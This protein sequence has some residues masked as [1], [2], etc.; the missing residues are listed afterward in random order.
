MGTHSIHSLL[1]YYKM[2]CRKHYI[3]IFICLVLIHKS[4][5]NIE[6]EDYEDGESS[7]E[8]QKIC[9]SP[10]EYFQIKNNTQDHV[11]IVGNSTDIQNRTLHENYF[12]NT[13]NVRELEV[14][15]I[16][17][18]VDKH[19]FYNLT[20]L[21]ILIF[22]MTRIS[23][24]PQEVF[25]GLPLTD[26]F[27]R[28]SNI[29][30][31]KSGTFDNLPT[32]ESLTIIS[33]KLKHLTYDTVPHNNITSL[34]YAYNEIEVIE[35]T[36]FANINKLEYLFLT[37]NKI[38]VFDFEEYLKDNLQL[39]ILDMGSNFLTTVN[40]MNL[41]NL[42]ELDLNANKIATILPGA[43]NNCQK[44]EKLIVSYNELKTFDAT[45]LPFHGLSKLKL[46]D[47][48]DNQMTCIPRNTLDLF[49]NLLLVF[50]SDNPFS[51]DCFHEIIIWMNKMKISV[52]SNTK[53]N[54]PCDYY[55]FN[56]Y[57]KSSYT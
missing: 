32:L 17:E 1:F 16:I 6:Y 45:L 24:L 10:E 49:P 14:R 20:K 51:C 12:Y 13:P 9:V 46:F 22:N 19:A 11:C 43:F 36:T 33:S 3:E 55:R 42:I 30:V 34:D 41:P 35:P 21:N 47:I 29:S 8:E 52:S 23:E 5:E 57:S 25:Q 54:A 2:K 44:L 39:K 37:E 18:S 28:K 31:I 53:S 48:S 7:Y 26:I 38:S 4:Y 40:S 50:W 56:N 27:I 15:W